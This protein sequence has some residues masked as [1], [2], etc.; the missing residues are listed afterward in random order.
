MRYDPTPPDLRARPVAAV[1]L[2][3]RIRDLGSAL[4]LW[5]FQ[6][7]IGFD[8]SDQMAAIKRAWLAWRGVREAGR[9]AEVRRSGSA[10]RWRFDDRIP[11][12]EAAWLL[13]VAGGVALLV[14]RLR[15]ARVH[16]ALPVA[17]AEALRLLEGRRL[18][19]TAATT[20]RS[21]AQRVARSLPPAGP[22]FAA[23]TEGYL[24]QRFGGRPWPSSAADLRALREAVRSSRR[25]S[26]LTPDR[27]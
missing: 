6:R 10:R 4:E 16:S 8:R 3:T 26:P 9:S 18:D 1:S 15:R 17:Y 22:A 14:M 2:A 24:A 13:A 12:R 7:V 21:F 25:G 20:A 27:S 5:W 11:W 19:R 23:L